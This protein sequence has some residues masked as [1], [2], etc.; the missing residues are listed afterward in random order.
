MKLRE[1]IN[2][3]MPMILFITVF[4]CLSMFGVTFAQDEKGQCDP[5]PYGFGPEIY[6]ET[7]STGETVWHV[8]VNSGCSFSD[9]YIYVDIDVDPKEI[10]DAKI[11]LTNWDVDY[12][13]PQSC[14]GG[15]EV[16]YLYVNG[17]FVG[18]L[19]GANNSWS[20]NILE[21]PSSYLVAG[22]N[23]VYIDV[24]APGT[25]CWCVGV[26]YVEISGKVGFRV[27][28]YTPE[29]DEENVKWHNPN[30]TVE[31]SNEV[32]ASTATSDTIILDYRDQAGSWVKVST[33]IT[34]VSAIKAQV[35]PD[36][37]LKDG[38]RYRMRVLDGPTGVMD[39][40]DNEL[41][42]SAEWYF[43]TMVN[44]DGQTSN[45]YKPNTT[46]DKLQI[47]WFN[48]SRNK[49]LI[50]IKI[51]VN[52]IYVLWD[53]KGDVYD[54][55]EVTEFK[56]NV[57]LEVNGSPSVKNNQ[58]LKRPDKYSA[59]EKR[60]A[61][62]TINFH[63]LG[64]TGNQEKY[65]LNIEPRP[66]K[67]TAG[68]F[69]K[70][71]TATVKASTPSIAYNFWACSMAGWYNGPVAG[72]LTAAK[73]ELTRGNSY[74]WHIF[75]I[76]GSSNNDKR[77]IVR[78]AAGFNMEYTSTKHSAWWGQNVRFVKDLT[79]NVERE[80]ILQVINHLTT[81]KPA[82]HKFI[83]G[84][85]P[86]DALPGANGVSAGSVILLAEGK[87]NASTVAHEIGHQYDL[88]TVTGPG[89]TNKHNNDGKVIEGFNVYSVKNKSYTEGN[90]EYRAANHN[91]CQG[92]SYKT[93]VLPLM[94]QWG[95]DTKIRW[96]RPENYEHLMG[97][98]GAAS[99]MDIQALTGNFM[100]VF[101]SIDN[102][103]AI[104]HVSPLYEVTMRHIAAPSGTGYTAELFSG[105]NGAGSS[106]GAFD[107]NTEI[108]HIDGPMAEF[109]DS[110]LFAFTIPFDDAAQSLVITG[111]NNSITINKSDNGVAAPTASFT[112]PTDGDA[113][114]GTVNINWSGSDDG[115]TVYYRLEFS[116]DGTNW[117][118]ISN[119]MVDIT[120]YAVDT[121]LLPSGLGQ[122]LALIAY[123]GFN[124]TRKEIDIEI[125][126]YV[127]VK[128]TTP[129]DGA[130]DVSTGQT[131]T[132][133]FVSDMNESTINTA[134]F[135][136]LKGG[137]Q[138]AGQVVYDSNSRRASFI[139][140]D[141]LEANTLYTARLIAGSV[142]DNIPVPNTL[143]TDYEW[144]FTT[145]TPPVNPQ[146][147]SVS[148][149]HGTADN[150]VNGI[151]QAT[152]E[153]DIDGNTVDTNSFTVIDENNNA[154]SGTV[155]YN[156]ATKSAV[157]TPDVNLDAD[158]TYTATLTTAITDLQGLP[159]ESD[160]TW[161]FTTGS[162]QSKG[163]RIVEVTHDQAEDTNNDGLYDKLIIRIQVEV[164]TTGTY[165]LN[166]QLRDKNGEDIAW[167]SK[168][169][170]FS[171]A[172]VYF[173]DLE[174]N[175]TDIA[176]HGIDGP[177]EVAN[178]Y[179]YNTSDSSIYH[180]FPQTYQ[181]YRY[182]ADAFYSVIR[183]SNIPEIAVA[184][185]SANDDVLNLENYA[186]HT[187]YNVSDL[188][189]SILI[190]SNTDAGVSIDASHNL[191]VDPVAGFSGYS[192]VTI[193]VKDQDGVRALDRFRVSVLKSYKFA[194]AGWKLISLTSQPSNTDIATVLAPISGKYD[195]VWTYSNG[196][197]K[198]YFPNNPGFSDLDTMEAG[199]GYWVA[200]NQAANLSSKGSTISGQSINLVTGWN[201]VGLN[202]TET[203]ATTDALA[204]I[205]GR[206][207]SVWAYIG[208]EWKVYD[209]NNPALSD[210][211]NMEPGYGY[212]INAIMDT[213]WTLP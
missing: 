35:T 50:P 38:I 83:I 131:V 58:T 13:D 198:A 78:G 189:Y 67:G 96:I 100:V 98:L 108:L 154:V 45:L 133:Y 122:K 148:P 1:A 64:S 207:L 124:T 60:M 123:D 43:W 125:D 32:T 112:D 77:T 71:A 210:L 31:F 86:D 194:S 24:D 5:P 76:V 195:S 182:E 144:S 146:I 203:I 4:S 92:N 177:F 75:P 48:V 105:E 206:Y 47:T 40:D 179:I 107:F 41:E 44:L 30:I 36:A 199:K 162:T 129:I 155:S 165:N 121:T 95:V 103:S 84:L 202:L 157:F 7:L 183:L 191:N 141:E 193:E 2:R 130:T 39:K 73:A 138:V 126:N 8:D 51:V 65:K 91:D 190:N 80:E 140:A 42:A 209:P 173:I 111:P 197:W 187:T 101:G 3:S 172:G 158:T 46:K 104:E 21:I 61:K 118:P 69:E 10:T 145:G 57:T 110:R 88:A 14:A 128:S 137:A 20:T 18:Q 175:G 52:R 114:S 94:N 113:I 174:F 142:Y 85:V 102:T 127:T 15:P 22:E 135:L 171:P 68:V 212:W 72:E 160:Y 167:N 17:N 6:A 87:F 120:T 168:S 99:V 208:G 106:L 147:A 178:I 54:D 185:D 59:N 186:S 12:N 188:N 62:N 115:G 26:G 170:S 149:S 23:L 97:K 139:P 55:D 166:S 134:T 74:T 81:L 79:T 213:T 176:S 9:H 132:A 16:D 33:T 90:S 25:G 151:I 161:N 37:D 143:E 200:L 211:T 93:A 159:L 192:D 169:Q 70:E 34:M 56:A 89:C 19:Q 205:A 11:T 116:P 117:I 184:I 196:V 152:F 163:V 53:P 156:A 28:D 119:Q 164:I 136:L 150:P 180:S 63:R 49:D 181:T 109:I 204:S 153:N 201:L 82:S 66:Q 29:A 27:T